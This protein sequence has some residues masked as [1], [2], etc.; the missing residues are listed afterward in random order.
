M[1]TEGVKEKYYHMKNWI[2]NILQKILGFETYIFIFSIFVI[3][4]LRWD[5]NEKDFLKLFDLI[6][7][8][9]LVLD[10]GANIGVMTYHFARKLKKSKVLAFEPIPYNVRTL[11]RIISIFKLSNVKVY[12]IALSDAD[13][14][15]KMIMPVIN[16][17]RKQGLSH[18]SSTTTANNESG[19]QFEVF[20]K[21][22][23]SLE[24]VL[25]AKERI[26]A[27]KIDVEGHELNVL[28]GAVNT[29]RKHKPIIYCELWPGDQR[30]TTIELMQ[31][32]DYTSKVL[33]D[34]NLVDYA[35]HPNQNFFFIPK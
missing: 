4:K 31:S 9:G 10:I 29:I 23:D 2:I 20:G 32:L 7:E 15:V 27:I 6:K 34:N 30:N 35:D 19:E 13:G 14:K 5:K 3:L 28:R 26:T 33:V 17:A 8:D 11:N 21:R 12:N 24:D 1:Q 18:V 16:S 22:L 25:N